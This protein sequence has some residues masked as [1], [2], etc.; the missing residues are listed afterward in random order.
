M[1]E[2]TALACR[3]LVAA[4]FLLPALMTGCTR[5]S[6]AEMQHSSG[7]ASIPTVAAA[8]TARSDMSS[9]LTLTAE[10]E[11]YQEIDVMAKVSGYLRDI[12]VDMGDR[13]RAGQS[14]A[15]IE[16]PEMEDDLARASASIDEA[17]ANLATAREE[18]KS[19]QFASDIAHLSYGRILDVSKRE[20]GLIPQQ[21]VDEAQ[22]RDLEAESQVASAKSRISSSEQRIRVATAEQARVKTLQKYTLITAPFDGVITKRYANV[23]SMIQAGTASQTQAMPLVRLSENGLLRLILPVPESSVAGIHLGQEVMVNVSAINRTFSGRVTRFADTLQLATRTMDTEVDVPNP[24][25]V[26]IP[27]MYAEVRLVMQRHDHALTVPL[28]AIDGAGSN[29]QRAYI[30]GPDQAIHVVNVTTGLENS[31]RVEVLS[32]LKDEEV[33]VIGRHAD[34]REGERVHPKFVDFDSAGGPRKDP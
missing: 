32:G 31:D 12:K 22:S 7:D 4:A 17:N 19:A 13:V 15:T 9:A 30:I 34:L 3:L 11:P 16:V 5:G 20:H 33:V 24:A 1:K 27:G 29:S 21:E 25:L 18:L 26:L 8:R 14:L 6:N 23:G 28:D 2:R 10:F